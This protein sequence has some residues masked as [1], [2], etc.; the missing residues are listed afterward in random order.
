VL[1]NTGWSDYVFAPGYPLLGLK[2]TAALI[3]NN[4]HLPNI[5]SESDV[6]EKGQG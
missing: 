2:D 5:P 3:R 1:V 4:G 6:K